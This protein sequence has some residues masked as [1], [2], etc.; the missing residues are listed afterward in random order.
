M[1][2]VSDRVASELRAA[3]A[4]GGGDEEIIPVLDGSGVMQQFRASIRLP[5]EPESCEAPSLLN[6]VSSSKR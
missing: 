1:A 5:T 6:E 2:A 3:V 4:Q